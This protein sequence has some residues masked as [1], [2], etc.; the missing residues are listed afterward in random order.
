MCVCAPYI[1]LRSKIRACFIGLYVHY[2]ASE[3]LV[4]LKR[5][6]K[7]QKRSKIRNFSILSIDLALLELKGEKDMMFKWV[8]FLALGFGHSVAYGLELCK[9]LTSDLVNQDEIRGM[10]SKRH[11]SL[12]EKIADSTKREGWLSLEESS[13]AKL[14]NQCTRIAIVPLSTLFVY[15]NTFGHKMYDFLKALSNEKKVIMNFYA[16]EE[17]PKKQRIKI[18]DDEYNKLALL[19]LGLLGAE[20]GVGK[21]PWYFIE[22]NLAYW[23]L[24][25]IAQCVLNKFD[26]KKCLNPKDTSRG[27]TQIK[28]VP[29]VGALYGIDRENLHEPYL[30]GVATIGFLIETYKWYKSLLSEKKRTYKT[31]LGSYEEMKLEDFNSFLTYLYRGAFNRF[32]SG[33]AVP[34]KSCYY[35]RVLKFQEYIQIYVQP[36]EDCSKAGLSI[37]D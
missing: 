13:K 19:A 10:R 2:L 33:T 18:T 9:P 21:S 24:E 7:A 12:V 3:C 5:H 4:V 25:P 16:S 14:T 34:Q 29:F 27:P 30:T 6:F 22:Y 26:W 17:A 35:K 23:G 8:L 36:E 32:K 15:D 20:S 1:N 37:L 11:Q 28:K 31:P